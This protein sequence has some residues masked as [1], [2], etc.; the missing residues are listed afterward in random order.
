MFVY[1]KNTF[2]FQLTKLELNGYMAFEQSYALN[3][4]YL[5][6]LHKI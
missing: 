2:I 1:Y 5:C 4:L 6:K 3:V